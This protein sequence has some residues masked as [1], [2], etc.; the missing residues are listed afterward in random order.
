MKYLKYFTNESDY[1]TFKDS[2]DYVLPN[3]SYAVD[4]DKVFYSSSNVTNDY[5]LY[6]GNYYPEVGSRLHQ[7]CN[8]YIT[9]YNR[10]FTNTINQWHVEIIE[11]NAYIGFEKET[12]NGVSIDESLLGITLEKDDFDYIKLLKFEDNGIIS[13]SIV[14]LQ[15]AVDG[16]TITWSDDNGYLYD[17]GIKYDNG[18]VIIPVMPS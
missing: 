9:M 2:E 12:D 4:T 5:I 14:R 1:Q 8:K 18:Y 10:P 15:F 6:R 16:C 7:I 17:E 3:V 11:G 13:K